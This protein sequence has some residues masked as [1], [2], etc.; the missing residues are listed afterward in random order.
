MTLIAMLEVTAHSVVII[1]EE[2]F[3]LTS[4]AS[5]YLSFC[6]PTFETQLI[7]ETQV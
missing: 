4:P 7:A 2:P 5:Y 6:P 1:R 3:L